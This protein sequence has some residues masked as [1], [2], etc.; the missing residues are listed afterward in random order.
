[1]FAINVTT[2]PWLVGRVFLIYSAYGI[3][4]AGVLYWLLLGLNHTQLPKH[5]VAFGFQLCMCFTNMTVLL[6]Y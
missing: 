1:M 6:L 4:L 3:C 5:T 2:Q